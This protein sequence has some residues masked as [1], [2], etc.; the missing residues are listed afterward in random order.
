MQSAGAGGAQRGE[1]DEFGD[2]VDVQGL[3]SR[4][5]LVGQVEAD[6]L[7]GL[8]LESGFVQVELSAVQFVSALLQ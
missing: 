6:D 1:A 7:L 3:E 4:R 5:D 2:V 8:G